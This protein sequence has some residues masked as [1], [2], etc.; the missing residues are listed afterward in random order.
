MHGRGHTD[1]SNGCLTDDAFHAP[2]QIYTNNV[3]PCRARARILRR[4]LLS[5]AAREGGREVRDRCFG[6]NN[7]ARA[8]NQ[9]TAHRF[10]C[11]DQSEARLSEPRRGFSS[12]GEGFFPRVKIF[13]FSRDIGSMPR[14]EAFGSGV[15]PFPRNITLGFE[16]PAR[17]GRAPNCFLHWRIIDPQ[18]YSRERKN[19]ALQ[20]F[21]MT[22]RIVRKG[23]A[24]RVYFVSC[25]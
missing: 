2:S 3:S 24:S 13:P 15:P 4:R 12:R 1:G 21:I 19:F 10:A 11:R 17:Q 8:K 20:A 23:G 5:V 14:R 16:R 6:V 18:Y 22:L 9:M 7:F 25:H